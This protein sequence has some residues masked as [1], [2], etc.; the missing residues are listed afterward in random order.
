MQIG[1]TIIGLKKIISNNDKNWIKMRLKY[2]ERECFY[3]KSAKTN[4]C[5]AENKN[6]GLLLMFQNEV[7]LTIYSRYVCSVHIH[8]HIHNQPHIRGTVHIVEI[9]KTPCIH[10]MFGCCFVCSS[11]CLSRCS[12]LPCVGTLTHTALI[13]T[14]MCSGRKKS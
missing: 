4:E 13:F 7:W 12:T 11:L 1:S 5:K 9:D 10:S 2:C 14:Y 3:S 8:A 6:D